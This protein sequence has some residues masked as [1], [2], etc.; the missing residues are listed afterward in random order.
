M[1][2][3]ALSVLGSVVAAGAAVAAFAMPASA[4]TQFTAHI[5]APNRILTSQHLF[6]GETLSVGLDG[7]KV[8]V[9]TNQWN[10]GGDVAWVSPFLPNSVAPVGGVTLFTAS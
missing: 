10:G 3:K 6:V 4:S 8:K 5:Q 1:F 2:R 7:F 9:V